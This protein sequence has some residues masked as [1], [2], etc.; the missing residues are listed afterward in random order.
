MLWSPQAQLRE[1]LLHC[2]VGSL[3]SV[4]SKLEQRLN[5]GAPAERAEVTRGP[6]GSRSQT[7]THDR[8]TQLRTPWQFRR[9]A[10]IPSAL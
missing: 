4:H 2:G 1:E 9:T 7:P 6:D 10:H 5:G 3:G 8:F